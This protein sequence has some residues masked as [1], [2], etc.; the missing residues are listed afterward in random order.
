MP[1]V[2]VIVPNYNHAP[3]L[4]RRLKS[5]LDQT[6]SDFEL[7]ILDDCSPDASR[8]VIETF[9]EDPRVRVVYNEQNSG[10]TFLQWQKG[11]DLTSGKYVWI[12]ESDDFADP[13]FLERL[14]AVLEENPDVG[15]AF[16][17]TIVV[18][19]SDS[20]LGWYADHSLPDAYDHRHQEALNRAFVC[21]GKR[22]VRQFMFPWNT[23]PNASAVLFRR[24]ALESIGGP[25]TS[26]RLCGDWMI[27]C[28][29]LSTWQ[30]GHIPDRFNYFRQHTANVRSKARRDIFAREWLEVAAF[31]EGNIGHLSRSAKRQSDHFVAEVLL[32]IER[33][34]SDGRVPLRRMPS[35]LR[36][37]AK[38]APR[39]LLPTS[40]SLGRQ[41]GG[42]VARVVV[43][44]R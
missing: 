37:A 25:V 22:Y 16:S 27:Y 38:F 17:E 32:G 5:I 23:I 9:A 19:E 35:A 6:H 7:L 43:P 12:A 1:S 20:E 30:V 40:L 39:L 21:D 42:S 29:I 10:N 44:S 13:H 28:Q 36:R 31:V 4:P 14:F 3:Y 11:L 18:D 34:P 2:S 33:Q 24:S 15:L 26:M 8:D 41:I